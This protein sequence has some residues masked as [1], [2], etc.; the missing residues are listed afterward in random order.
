MPGCGLVAINMVMGK[1]SAG[2]LGLGFKSALQ[3]G[4]VPKICESL[5]L[6]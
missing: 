5:K 2:A 4:W 3:V 1:A 6:Q